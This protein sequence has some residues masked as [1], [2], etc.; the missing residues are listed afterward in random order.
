MRAG[1]W[2]L[3]RGL[4]FGGIILPLLAP[5]LAITLALSFVQAFSVFPSAVSAGRTGRADHG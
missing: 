1:C 2:V 4:G 5:G 3:E